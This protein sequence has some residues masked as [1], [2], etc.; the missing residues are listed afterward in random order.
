MTALWRKVRGVIAD[1]SD[2]FDSHSKVY[3]QEKLRMQDEAAG[4]Q[5]VASIGMVVGAVAL[6][7]GITKNNLPLVML[8]GPLTFACYNMYRVGENY[9]EVAKN[10]N[11]FKTLLGWGNVAGKKYNK[12]DNQELKKCLEQNTFYFGVFVDFIVKH[13]INLR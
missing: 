7:F 9:A 8:T 1:T 10:P 3:Q 6:F 12:Q 13:V 4:L 5:F 11:Q 2:A